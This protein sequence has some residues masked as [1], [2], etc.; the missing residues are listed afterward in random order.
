M[1]KRLKTNIGL[2]LICS[3]VLIAC[4][5]PLSKAVPQAEMERILNKTVALKSGGNLIFAQNEAITTVDVNTGQFVGYKSLEDTAFKTNLEAAQV[6]ARQLRLRNIGGIIVVDFIDMADV[7]HQK[8]VHST[9]EEFLSQDSARTNVLGFTALNLMEITRKR[10]TENIRDVVSEPCN[11]CHG[12]GY[13][14]TIES[15]TFK[16]FR[17][18]SRSVKQFKAS[19]ILVIAAPNLV[20][21]IIDEHSETLSEMEESLNKRI[22]LQAEESYGRDQ[23]DV[24]LL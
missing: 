23:Y 14:Q 4:R 7:M 16:L 5:T 21:Y 13:I 18:I 12:S 17:E 15:N 22:T 19:K 2:L 6:I 24:V 11:K 9:L 3:L 1:T 10:T 8:Q 20:E